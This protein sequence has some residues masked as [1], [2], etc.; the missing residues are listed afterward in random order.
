MTPSLR[1][2]PRRTPHSV[3]V[4]DAV[5]PPVAAEKPNDSANKTTGVG[6]IKSC[7]PHAPFSCNSES[8]NE[9]YNP[10]PGRELTVAQTSRQYK[11][12]P[13]YRTT[14]ASF[15][16]EYR[17]TDPLYSYRTRVIGSVYYGES[18]SADVSGAVLQALC[19]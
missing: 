4:C 1:P 7:S 17:S 2:V 3:A 9:W 19:L 6:G 18:A 12:P 15:S 11:Y 5:G 14:T 8:E 16:C 10:G 13:P